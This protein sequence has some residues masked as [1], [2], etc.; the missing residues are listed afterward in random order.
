MKK[1]I[2]E[3]D[4]NLKNDNNLKFDNVCFYN[5]KENPWCIYGLIFDDVFRRMPS[6]VADKINDGV[7]ALHT[8]TSGGRVRFRTNSRYVSIRVSMPDNVHIPHMPSTG[9]SGFDMYVNGEYVKTFIPPVELSGGYEDMYGFNDS[10]E[11]DIMINFPL[12]N[13][14]NDLYIGLQNG[15]LFKEHTPYANSSRIVYYGSS[16]TQGGCVSRPGLA[17]TSQVSA[18]LDCDFVNL[19]FSGSALG[20]VVM[21]EYIAKINPDIFVLDYDHNAPTLEHLE[22]THEN[23]FNM[24]RSIK[25][26]TPVVFLSA[27]DVRFHDECWIKRRDIVF[28]TYKNAIKNGDKNVFFIDGNRLWNDEDWRNCS[29][30]CTHPNDIGH[31]RMA[32]NI[33]P[34]IQEIWRNIK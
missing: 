3:I 13:N 6:V 22:R 14:V 11:K 21:A 26:D 7:K 29:V 4:K 28:R 9:V 16:I 20:E 19:G 31:Y 1:D 8:N 15:S 2:T 5:V 33:I 18:K 32:Q 27:P 30:D 17:Y 23:F 25:K 34:I 10:A 24:F 12:Y